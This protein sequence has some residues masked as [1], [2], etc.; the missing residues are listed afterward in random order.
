MAK[1]AGALD[2]RVG[3]DRAPLVN[4]PADPA[5][6][7]AAPGGGDSAARRQTERL[8]SDARVRAIV[9]QVEHLLG[10]PPRDPLLFVQ[11]MVHASYLNEDASFPLASNERL[12]FL[13]D[14]VL[15]YIA[16]EFLYHAYP[17]LDEGE[18]SLLRDVLVRARTIARWAHTLGLGEQALFARGV[19][20]SGERDRPGVLANL[21]EAFL[22][23]VALDQGLERA[24]A[25]VLPYLQPE[26]ERALLERTRKD[27]KTQLNE[28]AQAAFQITPVYRIVGVE[29]SEHEKLF[30][31]QVSLRNVPLAEATARNK[32]L[33]SQ[34]AAQIAL[35]RWPEWT[36]EG[37]IPPWQTRS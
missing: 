4:G 1:E 13:G 14:S 5:A 16:T 21:F 11:A 20:P 35:E 25:F 30:R 34:R 3:I 32:Q 18:L 36:R 12:E 15:G 7:T 33:A 37:E 9:Q 28:L 27:Y 22:G 29:G 10:A 23:A 2:H 24:R 31:V 26:A 8:L 19:R 17:S 6:V